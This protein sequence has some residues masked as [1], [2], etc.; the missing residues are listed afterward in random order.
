MIFKALLWMVQNVYKLL[1][2]VIDK[3][4]CLLVPLHRTA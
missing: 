2:P 3:I 4:I 1:Q